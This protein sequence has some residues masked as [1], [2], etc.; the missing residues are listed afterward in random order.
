M[1]VTIHDLLCLIIYHADHDCIYTCAVYSHI[2]SQVTLAYL[3]HVSSIEAH[4]WT[5]L[6]DHMPSYAHQ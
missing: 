3:K 5:V 1:H 6:R 2:Y 4:L